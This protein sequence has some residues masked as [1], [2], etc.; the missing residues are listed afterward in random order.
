MEKKQKAL[1]ILKERNELFIA[2]HCQ[3]GTFYADGGI[4]NGVCKSVS[5]DEM[6][7]FM[8]VTAALII[9]VMEDTK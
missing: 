9:E 2:K 4:V 6:L 1:Q 8:D 3:K 5:A 7:S